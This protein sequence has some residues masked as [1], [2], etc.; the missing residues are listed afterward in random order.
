M[1]AFLSD[2][3]GIVTGSMMGTT[4]L[5]VYIESAAGIEDGGRTGLTGATLGCAAGRL[6]RQG[7]AR[8]GA[9]HP[10]GRYACLP[11]NSCLW[12]PLTLAPCSAT[13]THTTPGAQPSPCPSFS[14]SRSSSPPSWPPS[15]PTPPGPRSCWSVGE[16]GA[17]LAGRGS[18]EQAARGSQLRASPACAAALP[19]TRCSHPP[20]HR[21]PAGWHHPAGPHRAHRVGRR[22]GGHPRLPH[23]HPHALHLLG[24]GPHRVPAQLRALRGSGWRASWPLQERAASPRAPGCSDC[25]A[26]LARPPDPAWPS[27]PGLSMAYV[28]WRMA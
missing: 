4:P 23:H 8:A 28:Q 24:C 17:W 12:P 14:W 16:R 20:P 9:S 13:P 10:L 5:T 11:V 22:G 25:K 7:A 26:H 21:P 19:C 2:G 3:I 27:P 1:W 6:C 18:E 15:R